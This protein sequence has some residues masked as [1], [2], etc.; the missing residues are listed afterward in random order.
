MLLSIFQQPQM[1][2][3]PQHALALCKLFVSEVMPCSCR[4][5]M[6]LKQHKSEPF[7]VQL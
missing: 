7:I 2:S 6:L 4:S 1:Y 5:A 3:G